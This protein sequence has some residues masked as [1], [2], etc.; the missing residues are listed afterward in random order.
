MHL[1]VTLV[2]LCQHVNFKGLKLNGFSIGIVLENFKASYF[3]HS[4]S[5][6]SSFSLCAVFLGIH[7]SIKFS[8]MGFIMEVIMILFLKSQRKHTIVT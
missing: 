5:D 8:S 3:F 7:G 6:R 4:G 1:G 2:W